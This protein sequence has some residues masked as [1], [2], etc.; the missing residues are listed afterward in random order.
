MSTVLE[1]LAAGLANAK[2]EFEH[3]ITALKQKAE[4]EKAALVADYEKQIQNLKDQLLASNIQVEVHKGLMND[5]HAA[6]AA[7]ERV[8]TTLLTQF[9]TISKTFDEIRTFA[10]NA[11]STTANTVKTIE[12]ESKNLPAEAAKAVDAAK[13]A[14]EHALNR[15][16]TP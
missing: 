7:A 16:P 1:T 12:G 6:R 3:E 8:T 2:D 14:I 10:L 4:Q 9:A 11:A 5:A 15:N 13:V